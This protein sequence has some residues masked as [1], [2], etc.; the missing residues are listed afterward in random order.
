MLDYE[1]GHV[2][3]QPSFSCILSIREIREHPLG[4]D[5]SLRPLRQLLVQI[6]A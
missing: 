6:E 1:D 5:V 3:G 2:A 4:I